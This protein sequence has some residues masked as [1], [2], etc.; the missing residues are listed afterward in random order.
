MDKAT[1]SGHFTGSRSL[2]ARHTL[3]FAQRSIVNLKFIQLPLSLNP[4]SQSVQL[5]MQEIGEDVVDMEPV[6]KPLI[7][8]ENILTGGDFVPLK[9][10]IKKA[11]A[12]KNRK[13]AANKNTSQVN[14]E[15]YGT[16]PVPPPH[17]QT[18]AKG[19]V[20]VRTLAVYA[21]DRERAVYLTPSV[22]RGLPN[23]QVLN[24]VHADISRVDNCA[25]W[26]HAAWT[27]PIQT[28]VCLIVL[29]IELGPSALAGFALFLIIIPISSSASWRRRSRCASSRS[30]G[31]TSA[32]ERQQRGTMRVVKYFAT[33]IRKRELGGLKKIQHSQSANIAMT[34]SLPVFAATLAFV[35]Y[36][37][38]SKAFDVAVVF[39]SFS[40]FQLLCQPM[41][42]LPRVLSATAD[43]RTALARLSA[44]FNA[45]LR[46]GAPFAVDTAMEAVRVD[47][48]RWVW[49]GAPPDAEAARAKG[50]ARGKDKKAGRG[51]EKGGKRADDDADA[52]AGAE[53]EPF[54]LHGHH[55][56]RPARG[57]RID[58]R[59]ARR[60]RQGS[61]GES[62]TAAW[63]QNA[64]PCSDAGLDADAGDGRTTCCLGS[65]STGHG[66]AGRENQP[67]RRPETAGEWSLLYF[68]G[69]ELAFKGEQV[70]IARALYYGADIILFDDPLSA[71]DANVGKALFRT[72]ILG[73]VAQGKTVLLV[74]HA[75]HFLSQCD[76]I[77]TLDGGRIAEAGTSEELIARGSAFARLDAVS[78]PVDA[79]VVAAPQ[80]LLN[81]FQIHLKIRLSRRNS[82]RPCNRGP[83][84]AARSPLV[85][86][87]RW[88]QTKKAHEKGSMSSRRI[89]DKLE[90]KDKQQPKSVPTLSR[91]GRVR[92]VR[93]VDPRLSPPFLRLPGAARLLPP[94]ARRRPASRNI[95]RLPPR[96]PPP[97]VRVARDSLPAA[98]ARV[99][100]CRP[101]VAAPVA[102][103][104]GIVPLASNR[105]TSS[106]ES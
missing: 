75:L 89:R 45:P 35:T 31:R 50:K 80:Q 83:E 10:K 12:P 2:H 52:D 14:P 46:V 98:R 67:V 25:Q 27:A 87:R 82:S 26:F 91:E 103:Y 11:K 37:E 19:T 64:T 74:T 72:A 41:M 20:L 100:R 81:P 39:A 88:M 95:R 90:M 4:H 24:H 102:R 38:I 30:C 57:A 5:N 70:N 53:V 63:I 73:L 44:A 48:C 28:A 104:P 33:D 54:R 34:F 59:P 58:R 62:R 105:R 17:A 55:D 84:F 40:L 69:R 47:A 21:R 8:K 9:P 6:V 79:C 85:A 16:R 29:L 7:D 56:A 61:V 96:Y 43:A 93:A 106:W 66:T 78:T 18:L 36:T 65:R 23:A 49:E 101:L 51:G 99:V 15:G 13:L 77:Y 71:V 92:L 22:R 42:F 3:T 97:A 1:K 68:G 94:A 76:Y 60:E 32:R 86:G